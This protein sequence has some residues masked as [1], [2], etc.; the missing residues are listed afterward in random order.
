MPTFLQFLIPAFGAF[1]VG[2]AL[3]WV[4]WGSR[5]SDT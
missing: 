2:L 5:S 1:L 3:A 4:I